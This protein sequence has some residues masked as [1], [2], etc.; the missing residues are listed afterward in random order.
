MLFA[1]FANLSETRPS[2]RPL[3]WGR[4]DHIKEIRNHGPFNCIIGSEIVYDFEMHGPL[5]ETLEKLVSEDGRVVLAIA[6]RDGE[7]VEFLALAQER[8]WQFE[9]VAEYDFS[10]QDPLASSVQLVVAGPPSY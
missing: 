9:T 10:I 1:N 5:L 7:D 4:L 6:H 2:V 3:T 8:G